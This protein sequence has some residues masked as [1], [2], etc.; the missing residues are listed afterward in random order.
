EVAVV[1]VGI[2]DLH[3]LGVM[4]ENA[5]RVVAALKENLHGIVTALLERSDVV[6]VTTI[7]PAGE[8]PLRRRLVWSESTRAR[9]IEV[10][11]AL[12]ALAASSERVIVLD[13]YSLLRSE[14]QEHLRAEYADQDFFL[15]V[16]SAAYATL[17]EE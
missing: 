14:R 3:P 13:A 15:H 16:N 7:F 2:N 10:N 9:I 4:P 8:V 6:V 1:Q 17:N 12:S 11:A 5:D